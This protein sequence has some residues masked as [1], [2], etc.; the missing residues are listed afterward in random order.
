MGKVKK[1]E[2]KVVK[3]AVKK[4]KKAA[5]KAKKKAKKMIKK[6]K[7][8]IASEKKS[9]QVKE[10]KAGSPGIVM[11]KC[12]K[13]VKAPPGSKDDATM[14]PTVKK[15]GHCNLVNYARYCLGSCGSCQM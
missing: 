15:E 12:K 6:V 3:K 10:G 1:M 13:N 8:K 4:A 5:K 14:C 2:K 11:R 9:V 7:K